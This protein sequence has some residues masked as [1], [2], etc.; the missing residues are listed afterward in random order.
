MSSSSSDSP[1]PSPRLV[2][3]TDH[4]R[5]LAAHHYWLQ[6][7]PCRI[8]EDQ[9][10]SL[11]WVASST[12]MPEC[13]SSGTC[14]AFFWEEY[15]YVVTHNQIG[16]GCAD[17]F[18]SATGRT[19]YGP[20]SNGNTTHAPWIDATISTRACSAHDRHWAREWH[21]RCELSRCVRTSIWPT[22]SPPRPHDHIHRPSRLIGFPRRPEVLHALL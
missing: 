6:S 17:A 15:S 11:R 1:T 8:H 20:P 13:V 7:H 14:D 19:C 21:I 10:Y 18:T 4:L 3:V 16:A 9:R 5:L 2:H 12:P 22:P